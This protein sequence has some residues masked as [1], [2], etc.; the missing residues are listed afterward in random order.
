MDEKA[1]RTIQTR[2]DVIN[3]QQVAFYTG[4]GFGQLKSGAH[5]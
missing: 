5:M 4:R 1:K 3:S 2:I